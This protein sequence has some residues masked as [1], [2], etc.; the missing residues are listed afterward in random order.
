[1]TDEALSP[2][3]ALCRK[4]PVAHTVPSRLF[5]SLSYCDAARCVRLATSGRRVYLADAKPE[6]TP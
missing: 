5:G 6:V 3:C 1:M 2:V 4:R